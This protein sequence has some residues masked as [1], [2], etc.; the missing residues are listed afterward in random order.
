MTTLVQLST[1]H[2]STS[3]SRNQRSL[4]VSKATLQG[5]RPHQEDR[6]LTADLLLDLH[7]KGRVSS[8][9]KC[10]RLLLFAVCD[11][12]DY[13]ILNT[14]QDVLQLKITCFDALTASQC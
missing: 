11:G 14:A 7:E 8:M 1:A 13:K 12:Q 3:C 4:Y 2:S 10:N 6:I 9:D 5:R